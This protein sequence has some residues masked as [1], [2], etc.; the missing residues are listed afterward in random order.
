MRSSPFAA[1]QPATLSSPC[2][3]ASFLYRFKGRRPG[4]RRLQQACAVIDKL[5]EPHILL[6][7]FANLVGNIRQMTLELIARLALLLLLDSE[8]FQAFF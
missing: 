6:A 8:L 4:L 1:S 2:P 3:R 5:G 7:K